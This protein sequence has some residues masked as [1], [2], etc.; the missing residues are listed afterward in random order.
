MIAADEVLYNGFA[1][2][3][4]EEVTDETVLVKALAVPAAHLACAASL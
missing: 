3:T 2:D 1:H 4:I